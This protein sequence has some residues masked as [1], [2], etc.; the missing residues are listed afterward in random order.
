MTKAVD[1]IVPTRDTCELTLRCVRAVLDSESSELAPRC[2][3]VDNGSTDGT[4]DALIA[5]FPQTLVIRNKENVGYARA[6]N[7]GARA[8]KSNAILLLNSDVIA[9]PAAIS[10]LVRFLREN[11]SYV[12]AG[13]RLVHPGTETPQVGFVL[14]GYPTLWSQLALIVGFERLWPS[15]PISRRQLMLDLDYE[16]TQEVE[17]QPA[18]AC[19]ICRR[20]DFEAVG[21]FD[22][23]FFFW[24]ED[25]D[26]ALRLRTQGHIAYVHD[27]I[28]EH[29]GSETFKQWT[30]EKMVTTRYRSL[31][32][33]FEKHCTTFDV[34]VLR[35]VVGLL[36]TIRAAL[37]SIVN[38]EQSRAYLEVVRAALNLRP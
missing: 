9:R 1:V 8:G 2:I 20:R 15:N 11:P 23:G 36:A 22:E 12:A 4:A 33:Y 31:F 30:R 26:L 38:R 35:A 10:K 27:A 3:V 28:F 34:V 18:G 17:A 6:C 21:G 24:F 5:H 29:L 14:R 19:F 32:R 37:L 13:G 7:Q 16:R 25:V